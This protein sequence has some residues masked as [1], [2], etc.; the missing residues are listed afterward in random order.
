[1]VFNDLVRNGL[2][3]DSILASN[4][5]SISITEIAGSLPNKATADRVIGMHFMNPVLYF[6]LTKGHWDALYEPG[7]IFQWKI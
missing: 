3:D 1:M 6:N 2:P 7:I 4:T 5:S